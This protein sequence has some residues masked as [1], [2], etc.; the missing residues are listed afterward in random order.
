M[1]VAPAHENP[2]EVD[3]EDLPMATNVTLIPYTTAHAGGSAGGGSAGGGSAAG[4][5]GETKEE[6]GNS[7][8][9]RHADKNSS[10]EAVDGGSTRKDS[11]E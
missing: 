1:L 2:K 6:S 5:S 11:A 8:D 10:G 9:G 4:S 3:D 7:I